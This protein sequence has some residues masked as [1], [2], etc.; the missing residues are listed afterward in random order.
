MKNYIFV[1]VLCLTLSM[2]TFDEVSAH[3]HLELLQEQ[4]PATDQIETGCGCFD[5]CYGY[6][7]LIAPISF[8]S[9][10]F[11]VFNMNLTTNGN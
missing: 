6:R 3:S 11:T 7:D 4:P 5:F 1:I 10:L 2:H 8:L 9:I